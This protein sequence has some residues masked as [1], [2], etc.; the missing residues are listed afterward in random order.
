MFQKAVTLQQNGA[1][2][3][4]EQLYRQ[5]LETAPNNAD[6]LN[7]LGLIAQTKGIH[8]EAVAYFYQAASSAP[9]HF[10]IFFNLAVSLEAMGRHLEA[11]EA[12]GKALQLKPDLKEAHFGMGNIYWQQ[13]QTAKAVS[14]FQAALL[15]DASY[16]EAATNLAEIQNDVATLQKLAADN[17]TSALYYLGRRAIQQNDNTNAVKYLQKA[18]LLTASAEIKALLGRALL[19]EDKEQALKVFYQSAALAP[20]NSSVLTEIAD[21]EAGNQDFKTAEKY[22]KKALEADSQ[23]LRAHTNY[24]NMLCARKRTLEA[25]EEYRQAVIISPQTPEL[26]Y[27]LAIILKT[28]EEYEQALSLMFNAFYLDSSHTDWS[29]NL[30]ETLIL[31]HRKEQQKALKIAEN[32]Y[33]KMPENIVANHLWNA[34]NGKTSANE[35]AYNRLLF[36]TFAPTYEQTLQNINYAVIKKLTEIA[37]NLKGKILDLGCGTGLVGAALKTS[38]NSFIGVDISENMLR[39]AA[40]KNAYAEL[41]CQDILTYLKNMPNVFSTIIAADVFCYFNNLNEIIRNCH[42]LPLLFS[43]ETTTDIPDVKISDNGRYKHNPDYVTS[44][45]QQQGYTR[46]EKYELILRSENAENVN[47]CIFYAKI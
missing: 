45:L 35:T 30:A 11:I 47:G 8:N 46:I 42:N 17:N 23:N 37:P 27:N 18:D 41:I 16:T 25:L 32:W 7:L 40:D 14:E 2:N 28:L 1:L 38:D 15:I 29:L 33:N 6:V 12:Y 20:F 10:P 36:D 24:A 4:A 3:E 21:I 43:L 31:F 26:S 22:Y 19:S 9:K 44:V 34:L 13:N 39:L 5:I